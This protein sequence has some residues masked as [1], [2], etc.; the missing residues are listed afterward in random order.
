MDK[1]TVIPG[2]GQPD[3]F[4]QLLRDMKANLEVTLE[5][6]VIR[7]QVTRVRYEAL[8]K[9]GFTEAQALELCRGL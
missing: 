4:R 3:K 5:Y 2:A 8:L 1:I 7:A 6:E 9:Q